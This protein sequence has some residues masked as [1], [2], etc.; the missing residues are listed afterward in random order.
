MIKYSNGKTLEETYSF[1]SGDFKQLWV[2]PECDSRGLGAAGWWGELRRWWESQKTAP[3]HLTLPVPETNI[4]TTLQSDRSSMYY[5]GI[6][7]V[8]WSAVRVSV[9]GLLFKPELFDKTAQHQS[10]AVLNDPTQHTYQVRYEEADEALVKCIQDC[11]PEHVRNVDLQRNK[12]HPFIFQKRVWTGMTAVTLTSHTL[13]ACSNW[14]GSILR[15]LV[16]TWDRDRS[17]VLFLCVLKKRSNSFCKN[18]KSSTIWYKYL[19]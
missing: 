1:K 16:L 3:R 4:T 19:T 8:M 15:F 6:L 10:Q 7:S 18:V 14:R 13:L 17:C 11:D 9:G 2:W 5:F 12:S